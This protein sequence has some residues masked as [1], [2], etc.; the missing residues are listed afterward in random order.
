[1]QK[2]KKSYVFFWKCNNI[3]KKF[4]KRTSAKHTQALNE[5]NIKQDTKYTW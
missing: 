5:D 4:K 2:K 3:K 1:M